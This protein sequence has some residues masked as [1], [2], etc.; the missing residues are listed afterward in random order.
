MESREFCLEQYVPFANTFVHP[1][2]D[3]IYISWA[4]NQALSAATPS[5]K[6][7]P[8]YNQP[9]NKFKTVAMTI[10]RSTKFDRRFG[11]FTSCLV[12]LGV[13]QELL[14]CLVGP[15]KPS[16]YSNTSGF[17]IST[18]NHVV[19]LDWGN[20]TEESMSDSVRSYVSSALAEQKE[21]TPGFKVPELSKR[22]YY[23]YSGP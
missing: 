5:S 19:L 6:F 14:L 9:L 1:T 7:Y 4:Q 20:K 10:G 17:S 13:P 18:G 22:L 23:I 2:L 8:V 11:A 12:N 21:K 16:L 15:K 3:L